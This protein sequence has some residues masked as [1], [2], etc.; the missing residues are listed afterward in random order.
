[1]IIS[2]RVFDAIEFQILKNRLAS[3]A[4]IGDRWRLPQDKILVTKL[5]GSAGGLRES[6]MPLALG[7]ALI[8]M[9]VV[10]SER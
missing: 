5:T 3:S 10:I 6:R 2:L 9:T 8:L 1:L 4:L 7:A